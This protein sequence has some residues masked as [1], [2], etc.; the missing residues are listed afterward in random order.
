MKKGKTDLIWIAVGIIASIGIYFLY[1]NNQYETLEME[2]TREEAIVI[3]GNFLASLDVPIDNYEKECYVYLNTEDNNYYLKTMGTSK[4][5]N[6]INNEELPVHG[7]EILFHK[8]EFRDV[9]QTTYRVF[10]THSG[11][12]QSFTR[13]IP[14]SIYIPTVDI[15]SAEV[16]ITDFLENEIGIELSDFDLVS[17]H[18]N[19][20]NNRSD[21]FFRWE[22]VYQEPA[23]ILYLE[24]RIQGNSPGYFEIDFE[25]PENTERGFEVTSAL[26][27]TV[28]AV[29]IFLLV[30]FAFYF[31][32]KKYHQGEVWLKT[33]RKVFIIFYL[34]LVLNMINIWPAL[35]QGVGLGNINLI[36]TKL[37]LFLIYIL[38]LNLVLG[39]LVFTSWT[40]GESF[41]RELWPKKLRGIDSFFKGRFFTIQSGESIFYGFIIAISLVFLFNFAEY[42]LNSNTNDFYISMNHSL[43]IFSGSYPAIHIILSSFEYAFMSSFV[44]IFFIINIT[45]QKWKRKWLSIVITGL[46]ATLGNVIMITPPSVS[47]PPVD[48]FLIFLFSCS[49]AY[50][51][52]SFDLLT[53]FSMIFN[54]S[55]ITGALT[56]SA[57]SN[58]FYLYNLLP[59]GIMIILSPVIYFISRIKQDEF[60]LESF[61]MPSHI[62]RISER[63][64]LKKEMEIAAK[65]QLSLLPKENPNI[66]GYDIA[67][68]SIP[69][70]EAG[71]DYYDFVKLDNNKI[72]IAIGDVSGKGVGAAI[73]MT[74]TKGILQAHA[75]EN[76][77][78]KVVLG[79]VNKLLYKTMEKNSFVS[80]FYTILDI[81]NNTISYARAGHNPAIFCKCNTEKSTLLNSDGI[82][83]GLEIGDIFTRTLR[84]EAKVLDPGDMVIYYTDGFTEAMNENRQQ[85]GEE[86]LINLIESNKHK[87]ASELIHTI[88]R[89]VRKFM[90]NYPQ[91]DDMT[92]VVIHRCPDK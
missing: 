81:N 7:W 23:G 62:A 17:S 26:L 12:L 8:N 48:L 84:E 35:G 82:A 13:Q 11:K 28:S 29:F 65:V 38:I 71:G 43:T 68:L 75:E 83:L 86:R 47:Y 59:V 18:V 20:L 91:H 27:G 76:A 34:I 60:V 89:N 4:F 3:A 21:Y 52:F 77:S 24:A 69:A 73:Y 25:L 36:L 85:F 14:D 50:V 22:T 44:I 92:I 5:K 78:P 30:Q 9:P 33:G 53:I 39:L 46:A 72:G 70:V 10:L 67:G 90:D 31:F 54:I 41:A 80:M 64:R 49:F 32:I 61:G 45:Y 87:S 88:V 56:L 74:L 37:I 19:N 42:I 66:S 79:K 15:D 63:E 16:I 40:V 57:S 6:V 2:I 58:S 55:L 1:N 51:Y